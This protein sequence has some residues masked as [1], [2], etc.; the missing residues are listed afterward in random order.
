MIAMIENGDDRN[1]DELRSDNRTITSIYRQLVFT[2]VLN[3]P[4][5]PLARDYILISREVLVHLI[6]PTHFRLS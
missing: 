5:R 2:A 1:R 4:Q 3:Y 6:S